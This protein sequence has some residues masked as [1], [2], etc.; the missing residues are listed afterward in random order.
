MAKY[1]V[2]VSATYLQDDIK[3]YLGVFKK[4]NIEIDQP[5]VI[6][7]LTEPEL[8]KIIHLYNG[9]ICGDDE[10]TKP[11]INRAKNLKVIVKWGTG[12]DS[13]DSSY[14][15][16]KNIPVYRTTNAFT[17]PVADQAL[18]FILALVRNIFKSQKLMHDN[19]WEKVHGTT[20]S[21]KTVGIIGFGNIGRATAY[22]AQAFGSQILA[23]DIKK[24][25]SAIAKKYSAKMVSL[26]T[27][28]KQSDIIC[29]SC[30]LNPTS[31]H[32]LN[33]KQFEAMKPSTMVVNIA[34]GPIIQEMALLWALKNKKIAGAGLDV[35]EK[36]PLKNT[37]QL[38]KMDNVILSAHNANSSPKYWHRVHKNS[39]AMLIN[40]LKKKRPV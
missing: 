12:I 4:H 9:I 5:K 39:I 16:S 6:E 11:V 29:V 2:L 33:K 26:P 27:L 30:D 7:K 19:K 3:D 15:K 28:L 36:E 1:K 35:F 13:I 18:A 31:F 20:L 22:R 24:I 32:L 38:R 8:L 21:E 37:H 25:P 34:R 14:A 17:E 10:I 23:N 40:G